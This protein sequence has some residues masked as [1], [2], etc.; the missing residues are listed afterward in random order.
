MLTDAC[1]D[2]ELRK[3]KT[4]CSDQLRKLINAAQS[5]LHQIG[6]A[7]HTINSQLSTDDELA[8]RRAVWSRFTRCGNAPCPFPP[9]HPHREIWVDELTV[10]AREFADEIAGRYP[11][12]EPDMSDAI[13]AF[14]QLHIGDVIEGEIVRV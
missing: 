10:I 5:A 6:V 11:Q 3:H 13:N 2:Y 1:A 12:P 14:C 9:N 4:D 8:I 7:A